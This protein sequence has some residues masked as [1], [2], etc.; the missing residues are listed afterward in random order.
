MTSK[1]KK[2]PSYSVLS[3][4]ELW[5]HA[6][7]DPVSWN[8]LN[9]KNAQFWKELN[10]ICILF[11][12]PVCFLLVPT[13]RDHDHSGVSLSKKK[14]PI[15]A[16]IK[17]VAD[18]IFQY[19]ANAGKCNFEEDNYAAKHLGLNAL[20]RFIHNW[21]PEIWFILNNWRNGLKLIFTMLLQP[22]VVFLIQLQR[23]TLFCLVSKCSFLGSS[24]NSVNRCCDAVEW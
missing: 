20:S 4:Q 5:T 6:A 23:S 21:S 18:N 14:N 9:L 1:Q 15:H 17:S 22:S 3:V 16:S 19:K 10:T 11:F 24:W 8:L 7:F 12:Q 13:P 2:V